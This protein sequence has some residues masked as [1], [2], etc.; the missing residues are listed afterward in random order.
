MAVRP[1]L[2]SWD[3]FHSKHQN[4]GDRLSREIVQAIIGPHRSIAQASPEQSGKMLAVGS[5]LHYARDGDV[6]W[7]TGVNGN[8]LRLTNYRFGSIDVRAVRGPLSRDFI[9]RHLKIS[10]PEIYGDPGLLL[11]LFF[12]EFQ[13]TVPMKEAVVIVH[14]SEKNLFPRQCSNI[15]CADEIPWRDIVMA[16]LGAALVISSSL[17]GLI[18]AEAFRVPARMLRVS[19]NEHLFKYE[20]YYAGTNRIGVAYARSIP[21]ALEMGGAAFGDYDVAPLL[22]AFPLELWDDAVNATGV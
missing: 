6:I 17:H 21:E 13:R 5:I 22:Q 16:I 10:C 3:K 11:P 8:R 19:N 12:P 14:F 20:D 9:V 15:I 18:I 7:G 2:Y 1:R 4:F